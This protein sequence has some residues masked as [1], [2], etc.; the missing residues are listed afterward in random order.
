MSSLSDAELAT[1]HQR[2]IATET[3]VGMVISGVLSV[4]FVWLIFGSL[5]SVALWGPKGLVVDFIPQTLAIG[6]MAVLVPTLLTRKRLK[7]GK[8]LPRKAP[9]L[10]WLPNNVFL[11]ALTMAVIATVLGGIIGTLAL[12]AIN[13]SDWAL[14]HVYI[15]KTV[16]G[17]L[18]ATVCAPIGLAVAL[19][20][21]QKDD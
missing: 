2:Y 5:E 14:D 19:G 3:L 12:Q 7:A 10:Q 15:M 17:C 4:F 16:Y 6:F 11:R 9:L 1:Q 20:D 18:V 8:I 13:A 21:V